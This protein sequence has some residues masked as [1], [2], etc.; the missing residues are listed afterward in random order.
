MKSVKV[1]A[2]A[3]VLL[4]GEHAVVYGSACVAA[5]LNDL[6]LRVAVVRPR[7]TVAARYRFSINARR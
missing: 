4:F 3:K 5:A 6:R 1:S 2:P 7:Q